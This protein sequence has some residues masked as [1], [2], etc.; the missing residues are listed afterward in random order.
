MTAT[1]HVTGQVVTTTIFEREF[2]QS[3]RTR[4][5]P[6]VQQ[7]PEASLVGPHYLE[8]AAVGEVMTVTIYRSEHESESTAVGETTMTAECKPD[9]IGRQPHQPSSQ[10][11]GKYSGNFVLPGH[12]GVIRTNLHYFGISSK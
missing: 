10:G 4:N 7:Y 12:R 6:K 8:P 1:K 5:N 2:P 11:G 3:S 9:Q